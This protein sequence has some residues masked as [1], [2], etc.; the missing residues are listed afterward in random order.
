[1]PGHDLA[2]LKT[3]FTR[4]PVALHVLDDQ[5]RVIR[6]STTTRGSGDTTGKNLLVRHCTQAC[7]YNRP[8]RPLW[9]SPHCTYPTRKAA[10]HGST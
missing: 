10:A 7:P 2:V 3:L 1:M 4:S 8:H 6:T 9:R 5:L